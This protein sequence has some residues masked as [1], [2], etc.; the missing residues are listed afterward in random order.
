MPASM[1]SNVMSDLQKSVPLDNL[2]SRTS[3]LQ[4]VL[5]HPTTPYDGMVTLPAAESAAAEGRCVENDLGWALGLLFRR[6]QETAAQALGEVPGG[7]RGYQVLTL[8]S[9]LGPRR[10]LSL[11]QELSIDRTVMTY[12][13]DDLEA[14]G[15]VERRAD[16]ADRR[17]RLIAVTETGEAMIDRVKDCLVT[18]EDLLLGALSESERSAFRSMLLR[19]AVRADACDTAEQG[20]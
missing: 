5:R 6:Y 2:Q 12:L 14:A 17:A 3:I 1:R 15:L 18:A 7:P 8:A 11:A 10:Q 13:L 4:I 20:V 19:V 16:P 9:Q